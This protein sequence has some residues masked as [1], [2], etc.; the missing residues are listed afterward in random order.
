MKEYGGGFRVRLAVVNLVT[1]AVMIALVTSMLG[2][3]ISSAPVS[4]WRK[5][6]PLAGLIAF[7]LGAYLWEVNGADPDRR[8]QV[9][10][11][12][13]HRETRNLERTSSIGTGIVSE[14][15]SYCYLIR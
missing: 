2:T 9:P 5:W 11:G 7:I 14:L 3:W 13:P 10:R 1:A 12:W 4:D 15:R 8:Q 6:A